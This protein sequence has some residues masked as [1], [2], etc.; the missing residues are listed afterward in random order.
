MNV[1]HTLISNDE[2]LSVYNAT[3]EMIPSPLEN[4][5]SKR[6][7]DDLVKDFVKTLP[8]PK[9]LHECSK[10]SVHGRHRI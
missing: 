2:R 1:L 3:T 6:C 7:E 9:I 8:S 5:I 10:L 4:N